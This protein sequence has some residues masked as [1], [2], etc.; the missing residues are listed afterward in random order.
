MNDKYITDTFIEE[1]KKKVLLSG[2]RRMGKNILAIGEWIQSVRQ[3]KNATYEGKDFICMPRKMYD[4]KIRDAI[5]YGE[6]IGEKKIIE[7]IDQ[8]A[9]S[10]LM[11]T[12]GQL[13]T[14]SQQ[15]SKKYDKTNNSR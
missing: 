10:G 2:P 8:F 13:R 7:I 14:L 12:S 9:G 5:K 11:F 6:E 15:L 4:K 1:S 3:G